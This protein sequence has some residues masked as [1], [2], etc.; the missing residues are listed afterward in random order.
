MLNDPT[1][2]E[3]ARF[4]A[5]RLIRESPDADSRI[6]SAFLSILG[7]HPSDREHRILSLGL[8]RT[9]EHFTQNPSAASQLLTVGESKADATLDPIELA[10]WTL[11]VGSILNLEET[12]TR[13]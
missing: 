5:Q 6:R 4:L 9:Q 12:L 2:V 3:A 11:T 10:S 8:K 13:Q 1:Y 7:R